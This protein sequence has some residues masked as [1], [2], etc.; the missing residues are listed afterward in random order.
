MKNVVVKVS[1]MME[2]AALKLAGDSKSL[3]TWGEVT[4]PDALREE[5]EAVNSI[6]E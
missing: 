2:S 3:I 6:K 1:E 4:L 5:A